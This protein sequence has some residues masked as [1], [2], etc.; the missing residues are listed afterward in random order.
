[1]SFGPH[2]WFPQR[3]EDRK[4]FFQ[5]FECRHGECTCKFKILKNIRGHIN[6]KHNFFIE[7]AD[8]DKPKTNYRVRNQDHKKMNSKIVGD[9]EKQL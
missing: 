2:N 9:V 4:D 5:A 8:L 3:R 6:K 7:K 1:M